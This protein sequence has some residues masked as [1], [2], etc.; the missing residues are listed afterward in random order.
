MIRAAGMANDIVNRIPHAP[1][2]VL[3]GRAENEIV[4]FAIIPALFTVVHAE[5]AEFSN[6]LDVGGTGCACAIDSQQVVSAVLLSP[7]FMSNNLNFL[8][9]SNFT[10]YRI[11]I[12]NFVRANNHSDTII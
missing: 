12:P 7:F 10:C 4:I 11:F 6:D 9:W 1:D 8:I 3:L 5:P 2:T